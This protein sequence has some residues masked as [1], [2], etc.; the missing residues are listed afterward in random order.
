MQNKFISWIVKDVINDLETFSCA[1]TCIF[2][3]CFFISY[4]HLN[5]Y[6][7]L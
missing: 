1:P 5:V 6:G 4:N 2:S 3:I 7:Y